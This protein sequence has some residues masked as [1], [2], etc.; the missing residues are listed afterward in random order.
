VLA[1][2]G[3]TGLYAPKY[4]LLPADLRRPPSE[5]LSAL[6]REKGLGETLLSTNLPTLLLFECVLVYM[7]PSASSSL[8]EWFTN[9]FQSSNSPGPLGA[10]V[11]EMFGLSDSFG[12][13]MVNNLKVRVRHFFLR[14]HT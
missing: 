4:H 3:G 12:R 2:Q 14:Y 13:V 9:Y 10:I 6:T 1:A 7:S 8:I 11:Y 5:S